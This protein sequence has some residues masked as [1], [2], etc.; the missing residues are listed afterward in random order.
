MLENVLSKYFKCVKE[1]E[2]AGLV[3]KVAEKWMQQRVDNEWAVPTLQLHGGDSEQTGSTAARPE[4]LVANTEGLPKADIDNGIGMNA[5]ANA[6]DETGEDG[7]QTFDDGGTGA[8]KDDSIHQD[9]PR[10]A[11]PPRDAPNLKN[12][13]LPQCPVDSCL[14]IT[15]CIE[16]E[17]EAIEDALAGIPERE[18]N[19]TDEDDDSSDERE[20]DEFSADSRVAAA[21]GQYNSL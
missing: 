15:M 3:T 17:I 10:A 16:K 2:E 1:K 4:D 14:K 18:D 11:E 19:V 20:E 13:V 7:E 6:H 8:I 9:G 21:Q 12:I 5:S